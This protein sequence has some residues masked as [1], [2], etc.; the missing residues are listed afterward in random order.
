M[1]WAMIGHGA[2]PPGEAERL[3]DAEWGGEEWSERRGALGGSDSKFNGA[4]VVLVTWRQ[5]GLSG[6]VLGCWRSRTQAARAARGLWAGVACGALARS[7]LA[8]R[9]TRRVLGG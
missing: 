5:T 3:D 4:R 8:R 1:A 2:L 7:R 9:E 6:R